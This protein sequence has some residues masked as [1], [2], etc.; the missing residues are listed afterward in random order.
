MGHGSE[1][2]KFEFIYI[3]L[4]LVVIA[5]YGLVTEYAPTVHPDQVT[6][7]DVT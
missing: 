5:L 2:K 6:D 3:F 1:S 4:Q 7:E